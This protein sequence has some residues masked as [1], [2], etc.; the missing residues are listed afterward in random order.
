MRKVKRAKQKLAREFEDHLIARQEWLDAAPERME[1]AM[2]NLAKS[3]M[4][5]AAMADAQGD[6]ERKDK[7][8]NFTAENLLIQKLFRK[9]K[10]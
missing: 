9:K 2:K 6:Q 10:K 1:K 4:T 3:L 8:L 5:A 7:I